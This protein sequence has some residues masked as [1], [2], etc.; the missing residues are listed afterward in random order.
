MAEA[1]TCTP[2]ISLVILTDI[3]SFSSAIFNVICDSTSF[4]AITKPISLPLASSFANEGPDSIQTLEV[5]ISSFTTSSM[6]KFV[7][8][9]IPLDTIQIICSSVIY[10][11]SS[12]E[13][14]LTANIGTANTTTFASNIAVCIFIDISI[15][16]SN[17]TPGKV[18]IFSRCFSKPLYSF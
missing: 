14:L 2:L 16:S 8:C 15:F 1:A 5:S 17:F 9:S 3:F 6:N 12:L 7:F 10:L 11:E 13:I 18:S 4:E